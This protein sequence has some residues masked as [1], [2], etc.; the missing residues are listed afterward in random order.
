MGNRADAQLVVDPQGVSSVVTVTF[1]DDSTA[2]P[3]TARNGSTPIS[4]PAT[5]STPTTFWLPRDSYHVTVAVNSVT[6][7]DE[8]VSIDGSSRPVITPTLDYAETQ[9][10]IGAGGG[11]GASGAVLIVERNGLF[12]NL[13]LGDLVGTRAVFLDSRVYDWQPSKTYSPYN[14]PDGGTGVASVVN[15]V[16]DNHFGVSRIRR[17]TSGDTEPT[18]STDGSA[19]PDG[20]LVWAA[21]PQFQGVWQPGHSY[22]T[23]DLVSGGGFIWFAAGPGTSDSFPPDW[24]SQPDYETGQVTD[25]DIVWTNSGVAA[26]WQSDHLYS[27]PVSADGSYLE[28]VFVLPTTPAGYA[29]FIGGGFVA[30]LTPG[31]FVAGRAAA[32]GDV[33][34]SWDGFSGH[35][36]P[37]GDLVWQTTDHTGDEF[38]GLVLTGFAVPSAPAWLSVVNAGNTG[39]SALVTLIDKD[40]AEGAYGADA[41]STAGFDF[42]S[43]IV[44]DNTAN[45]RGLWQPMAY[46]NG[47]W[48]PSLI[49]V[50]A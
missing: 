43:N 33:E 9:G 31:G 18:W 20:Q 14:V 3:V 50:P 44:L 21:A 37:D 46:A 34:P 27:M 1:A 26:A 32:S 12:V 48:Q 22:L 49:P 19:V 13:D 30:N 35:Y 24:S 6:V 4:L 7:A 10:L 16:G 41:V 25:N 39:D 23:G 45:S 2:H 5:I 11:A 47:V 17:G 38:A 36:T 28:D 8:T 29:F 42:G 15:T 40:N